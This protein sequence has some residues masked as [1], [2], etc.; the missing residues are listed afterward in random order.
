MNLNTAI[1]EAITKGAAKAVR[2]PVAGLRRDVALLKRE[3]AELKRLVKAL[4]RQAPAA[5][6]PEA[7]GQEPPNIRP[8]AKMVLAFRKKL[9]LTQAQLASLVGVSN[10]T[11]SKWET[12]GGRLHMRGRALAGFARVRAMGK[13]E[14]KKAVVCKE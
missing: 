12:S 13:R 4:G 7:E 9:G 5:V 1:S 14:A 3:L 2:K 11:V 10:L 8:T 6:R